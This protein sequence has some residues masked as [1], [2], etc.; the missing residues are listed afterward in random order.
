MRLSEELFMR[1]IGQWIS[2]LSLAA[3]VLPSVVYL[4]GKM[5]L[6]TVKHIML[7]AT[8]VWFASAAMWMWNTSD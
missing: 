4:A 5:E 1:A 8:V 7:A 6:D 3:L 2:W